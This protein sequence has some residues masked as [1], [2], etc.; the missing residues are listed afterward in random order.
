M[1]NPFRRSQAPSFT[2]QDTPPTLDESQTSTQPTDLSAP[3]TSRLSADRI[4]TDPPLPSSKVKKV[5][6]TSPPR[7]P[8]PDPYGPNESALLRQQLVVT[9]HSSS[10]SPQTDDVSSS[11]EDGGSD[12]PFAREQSSEE[13]LPVESV[14]RQ[15][16]TSH[17]NR[18][19]TAARLNPFSRTSTIT[20]ESKRPPVQKERGN[21][22]SGEGRTGA[23]TPMD[24]DSF[25]NLLMT[26]K[27][28]TSGAPASAQ[29]KAL[30]NIQVDS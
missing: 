11:S 4:P 2:S 14:H 17:S 22:G 15:T 27:A 26:G 1:S 3:F 23:K 21:V 10:A 7:S 12:D 13:E 18:T 9:H 16:I 8:P 25:K 19:D 24:V 6:I 28:T 30:A 5:R 29:P 20:E